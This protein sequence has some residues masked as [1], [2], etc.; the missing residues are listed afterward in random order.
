MDWHAGEGLTEV[1]SRPPEVQ[2]LVSDIAVP[3][4]E[5]VLPNGDATI[6]SGDPE[7]L[8]DFNHKQGKNPFGFENDCAL[9][10]TQGV[11]NQHD[12]DVTEADVVALAH[13]HGLCFEYPGDPMRSGGMAPGRLPELLEH[14]GVSAHVETGASLQDLAAAFESGH[15]VIAGVNAGELWHDINAYGDG[16][17]NHA[18]VLTGVARDP[19]TRDIQ[20]FYI[21]DSGTGE[22][23][24]LVDVDTM[25]RAS[26]DA[27]GK[28]VVTDRV[29]PV[30]NR[31]TRTS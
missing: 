4:F 8:A 18:I 15:S 19:A 5:G 1:P 21:N 9:V 12:I 24:R 20:G 29:A 23:G 31:P 25:R 11:L 28:A 13:R 6:I 7:A 30:Y 10:A 3:Q 27:G 2:D 22:S 26:T 16:K 14:Y 17:D